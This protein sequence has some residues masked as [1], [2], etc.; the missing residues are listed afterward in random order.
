MKA[1]SLILKNTILKE[2]AA[3]EKLSPEERIKRRIEKFSKMG[4][5]IE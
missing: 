4:V 3:L 2:I 1:A 5:F